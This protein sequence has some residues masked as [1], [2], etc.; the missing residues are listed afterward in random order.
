VLAQFGIDPATL[1]PYGATPRATFRV[2]SRAAEVSLRLVVNWPDGTFP[3][4]KIDLGRRPTN[5]VHTV[6]LPQLV[7]PAIPEGVVRVRIAGRDTHKRILRPGAHASR[8]R[9]I[10][11]RGHTFPLRGTFSYGGA[12]ARFGAPRAG[13]IHQG[14]DL[15]AAEGTPVV[16]PR[17]GTVSYVENQPGGAGWYVV[18]SG[19]GEELDYAFMHLQEGSI[20]VQKGQHVATGERLGSVGH[21]GAAQG[22]HLHFEVWQG[23]WFDGGKAVDPLP[24]LQRW[25]AWSDVRAI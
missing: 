7:D 8:V 5:V 15:L 9:E 17:G 14:Q 13:H 16:A 24:Y 19:D 2:D 10:E 3:A 4:V 25:Q 23:A 11:I 20:V 1:Y 6:E 12:G 18:L 21:T 22:D